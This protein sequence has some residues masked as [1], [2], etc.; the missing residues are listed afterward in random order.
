ML[1]RPSCGQSLSE[2]SLIAALIAIAAISTL[3]VLGKY[4]SAPV[5][6]YS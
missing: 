1:N 5:Y 2:Y 3:S 4:A 6:E